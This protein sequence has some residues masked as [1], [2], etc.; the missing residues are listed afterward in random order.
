[1]YWI[2][3]ALLRVKRKMSGLRSSTEFTN[4]IWDSLLEVVSVE[5][6]KHRGRQGIFRSF[7]QDRVSFGG[8]GVSV[9]KKLR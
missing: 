7:L 3:S 1:M 2:A 4:P 8:S 9:E 6:K 5:L